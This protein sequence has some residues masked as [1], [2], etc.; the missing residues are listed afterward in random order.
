MITTPEGPGW[1]PTGRKVM[2]HHPRTTD[3]EDGYVGQCGGSGSGGSQRPSGGE[4]MNPQRIS[5]LVLIFSDV[6]LALAV[7][8]VAILIRGR[9]N[10]GAALAKLGYLRYPTYLESKEGGCPLE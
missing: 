3:E 4:R 9:N 5:N 10:S 1:G 8:G 6:V 7:W 2:D